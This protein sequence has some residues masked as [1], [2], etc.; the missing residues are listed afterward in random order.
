MLDTAG[1]SAVLRST[2]E[3]V[4]KRLSGARGRVPLDQSLLSSH[5]SG[6]SR[7]TGLTVDRRSGSAK[8]D[9]LGSKKHVVRGQG[10]I[11][12]PLVTDP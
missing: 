3:K 10:V 4:E 12:G 7:E 2:V 9:E 11:D 1:G 6:S 5:C 8:S